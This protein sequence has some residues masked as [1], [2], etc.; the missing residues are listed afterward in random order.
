MNTTTLTPNSRSGAEAGTLPAREWLENLRALLQPLR[1]GSLALLGNTVLEREPIWTA[2]LPSEAIVLL[3]SDGFDPAQAPGWLFPLRAPDRPPQILHLG[4]KEQRHDAEPAMV[5]GIALCR[6]A[7]RL[8]Q[9][10]PLPQSPR[11]PQLRDA[12]HSLRN[13]LNSVLM[14]AAV[15]GTATLPAA[16]QPIRDE[17]G[18]AA[19]RSLQSLHELMVLVGSD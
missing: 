11:T 14:N 13:G 4:S 2:Q 17:L 19:Q 12:V 6:L 9:P 5:L 10:S 18:S 8:Q 1:V 7:W 3:A 15:L 16:M